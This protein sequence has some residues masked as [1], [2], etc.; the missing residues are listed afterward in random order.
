M[1]TIGNKKVCLRSSSRGIS[2]LASI[3]GETAKAKD[4]LDSTEDRVTFLPEALCFTW[5]L[6]AF[7]LV[8]K[9]SSTSGCNRSALRGDRNGRRGGSKVGIEFSRGLGR[10]VNN[11]L[12]GLFDFF[13]RRYILLRRSPRF[14]NSSFYSLCL[15]DGAFLGSGVLR[16]STL[17]E[18]YRLGNC[19]LFSGQI[20]LRNILLFG[21]N[22][23][24]GR[25]IFGS[26]VF[27][28][29]GALG[30]NVLL[31]GNI[32]FWSGIFLDE[33]ILLGFR[34]DNSL[35]RCRVRDNGV[36]DWGPSGIRLGGLE[37][38]SYGRNFFGDNCQELTRANISYQ[39]TLCPRP[40]LKRALTVGS[41]RLGHRLGRSRGGWHQG[42]GLFDG[43]LC[44]R[45]R[46]CKRWKTK[47]VILT[48]SVLIG[49]IPVTV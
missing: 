2:F 44:I 1:S 6:G 24:R 3:S 29:S 37:R 34:G 13:L 42:F 36:C 14:R 7:G 43:N 31:R 11:K 23:L 16:N 18:H 41:R 32:L 8:W 39:L 22:Y 15:G 45:S 30:G 28:E 40:R 25:D 9:T 19:F 26:N 33:F 5:R 10:R 35:L 4:A 21:Y 46:Q 48:L 38:C 12:L 20:D 47:Y 27:L 17:L 49:S